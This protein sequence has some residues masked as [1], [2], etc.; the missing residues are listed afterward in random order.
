MENR[1]VGFVLVGISIVILFL[2]WSYDQAL[3]DIVNTSCTHGIACPMYKTID[4]QRTVSLGITG[5]ILLLGLYFAVFG[6][7]KNGKEREDASEPCKCKHGNEEKSEM[8]IP[9]NLPE[10]SKKLVSIIK[11]KGGSAYQSDLATETGFSKVKITRILDK[12]EHD[13]L[14]ERKRRGMTNIVVLK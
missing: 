2:I 5:I 8:E 4:T 6:G 14:I 7:K 11:E 10:E 12:L 3:I 13:G 9:E 1:A